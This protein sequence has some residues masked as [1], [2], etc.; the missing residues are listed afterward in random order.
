MV[1]NGAQGARRSADTLAEGGKNPYQF[2][3]AVDDPRAI[4]APLRRAGIADPYGVPSARLAFLAG[5]EVLE[6]YA[7]GWRG[8]Q[9]GPQQ[10][11][12]VETVGVIR[13]PIV[14]RMLEE[15]S[16]RSKAKRAARSM[17]AQH[18]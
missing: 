3:H 16:E 15:M 5:D 17:L 14:V 12:F 13:S 18:R 1:L 4:L 10:R 7:A 8:L 9:T 11:M 6:I 2:T